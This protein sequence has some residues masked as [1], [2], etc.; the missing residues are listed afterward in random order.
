MSQMPKTP[1]K[2]FMSWLYGLVQDRLELGGLTPNDIKDLDFDERTMQFCADVFDE[3]TQ[4]YVNVT[5][6]ASVD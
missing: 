4:Q 5:V 3:K 2:K 6:G 1:G